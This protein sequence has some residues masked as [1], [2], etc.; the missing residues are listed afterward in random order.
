M[1]IAIGADH[2]GYRLKDGIVPFI[3]SL[4][5]EI[6]DFGCNCDQIRSII[7]TMRFRFATLLRQAKLTAVF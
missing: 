1:K 3:Q 4:G 5:H 2:A 7:R 6:E